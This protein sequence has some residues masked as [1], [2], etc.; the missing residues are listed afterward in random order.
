MKRIYGWKPDLPIHHDNFLLTAHPEI[1]KTFPKI[2]ILGSFPPVYDQ[3]DIGS[4]TANAASGVVEFF[5]KNKCGTCSSVS[6]NFIY[7][8]TRNLMRTKGD[9]GA[10]I[11][12]TMSALELFG[13]P[14]EKYWEYDVEKYDNEPPSFCYSF[15]QNYQAIKYF[16]LDEEAKTKKEILQ[17]IKET[18]SKKIPIMFGF[19]VYSSIDNV[20]NGKI[21]YPINGE[22]VLGGHAVVCVGYD[23]GL[24]INDK[25]GAFIIRNSWG[26][27]WGEKGYGYLP[28]EYVL[29]GL[30][31]DWW[32]LVKSEWVDVKEF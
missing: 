12:T 9:S 16:R 13:V 32:A 30:A 23:D 25:I 20:M 7:K 11:R 3:K 26:E 18:I 10:Y 8:T 22:T 24:A 29:S 14:P 15:G 1:V 2:K 28:Y 4:C 17:N 5:L 27:T 21:P 31:L 6:R 19:T